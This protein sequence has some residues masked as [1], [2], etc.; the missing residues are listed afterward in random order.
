MGRIRPAWRRLDP[1][2]RQVLPVIESGGGRVTDSQAQRTHGPR[3]I[4]I[5]LT[6]TGV[7]VA[8]LIALVVRR[9]GL[10]TDPDIACVAPGGEGRGRCNRR[11]RR[12]DWR[13]SG[14]P[15][16]PH[17]PI[18]GPKKVRTQ[19]T[20]LTRQKVRTQ[21][22]TPARQKVRTQETTPHHQLRAPLS[23]RING[24]GHL[25]RSTCVVNGRQGPGS[26]RRRVRASGGGLRT[27]GQPRAADDGLLS[28]RRR[29]QRAE[30][31]SASARTRLNQGPG[32]RE[33]E[34]AVVGA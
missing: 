23:C 32:G 5:G 22:T 24:S 3:L 6:V 11:Y 16:S 17:R 4:I 1:V 2:G 8:I 34:L 21:E 26:G 30:C 9:D 20:T 12:A 19:G 10:C 13:T 29:P 15:H 7:A 25:P 33:D 31:D 27:V 18:H 14:P 28:E